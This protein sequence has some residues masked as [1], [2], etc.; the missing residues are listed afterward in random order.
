PIQRDSNCMVYKIDSKKLYKLG[1]YLT[2]EQASILVD[3]ADPQYEHE[4]SS[5]ITI[6]DIISQEDLKS[7]LILNNYEINLDEVSKLILHKQQV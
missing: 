5:L 4:L 3:F 6:H 2:Y 7:L 1:C